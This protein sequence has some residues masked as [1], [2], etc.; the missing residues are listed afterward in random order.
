[1]IKVVEGKNRIF[2][3]LYR[4]IIVSGLYRWSLHIPFCKAARSAALAAVTICLGSVSTCFI[5]VLPFIVVSRH[6]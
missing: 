5:S 6:I 3:I 2:S 4:V 1:V